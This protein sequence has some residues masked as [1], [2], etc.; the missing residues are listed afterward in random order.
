MPGR[1]SAVFFNPRIEAAA[2]LAATLASCAPL[3]PPPPKPVAPAPAHAVSAAAPAALKPA[4]PVAAAPA[5]PAPGPAFRLR[6]V[7]LYQPND[8]LTARLG[9]DAHPFAAYTKRVERR[10]AAALAGHPAAHGFSAAIVIAIKPDGEV[11][12]WLVTRRAPS[13]ALAADLTAAAEAVPPITVQGGPIAFAIV[14]DAFG[15][16]GP[17][18][19]DRAHPI[20]IPP[21]WREGASTPSLAPDGPHTTQ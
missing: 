5:Q 18:V 4:A 19:I 1:L 10:I 6:G 17:P 15:G 14:F 21:E 3:T 16:G 9:G 2:I 11:H 8:V 12:A 13:P 7:V 20:P